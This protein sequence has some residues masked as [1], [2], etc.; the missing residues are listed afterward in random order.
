MEYHILNGDALANQLPSTIKG[1]ILVTRECL[2]E[3]DVSG[4][5]L[6]EFLL[7]RATHITTTYGE[8]IENYQKNVASQILSISSIP[9]QSQ[10]VLWFEEDLF[11]QVNLWFVSSL[12]V[13][14]KIDAFLVLPVGDIQYGFGGMD[15]K[16]LVEA[17]N[18]RL[19]LSENQLQSFAELWHYYKNNNLNQLEIKGNRTGQYFPFVSKAISAHIERVPKK[20]NELSIL[21]EK[22]LK[23]IEKHG[24]ENFVKVFQEFSSKE[25]VYGFGDLQVKHLFDALVEQ[26]F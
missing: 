9:N 1:E 15:A 7:N 24:K 18:T 26:Y 14:K 6:N 25:S 22:M 3:G 10:V 11:C 19:K 21:D 23:M 12:L 20:N 4:N 16:Q 17:Y 13:G 5:T 2:V 8:S